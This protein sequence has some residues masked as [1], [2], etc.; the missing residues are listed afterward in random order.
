MHRGLWIQC[1]QYLYTVECSNRFHSLVN[2]IQG[3]IEILSDALYAN[4]AIF[5]EK[6]ID[7]NSFF[8]S[9]KSFREVTQVVNLAGCKKT[10]YCNPFLMFSF[11]AVALH[12]I[13]V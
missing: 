8:I 6:K 3:W 1:T 5:L 7:G 11:G 4:E 9:E 13:L 2:D 10:L 12:V